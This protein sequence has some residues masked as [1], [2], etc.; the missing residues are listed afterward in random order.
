MTFLSTITQFADQWNPRDF[1]P[2]AP[3]AEGS[4]WEEFDHIQHLISITPGFIASVLTFML[5]II[6]FRVIINLL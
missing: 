2:F 5:G 4:F 1:I 6:I 3:Q